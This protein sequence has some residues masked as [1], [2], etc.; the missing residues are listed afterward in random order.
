M[1]PFVISTFVGLALA[2]GATV[3]CDATAC[4]ARL[5]QAGLNEKLLA[6]EATTS[7]LRADVVAIA[8]PEWQRE[9]SKVS[10]QMRRFDPLADAPAEV[11]ASVRLTVPFT[12]QAPDAKWYPPYAEA[13]E[14]ASLLMVEYFL[15]GEAFPKGVADR[16]IVALTSWHTEHGYG[17]DV[18]TQQTATF[19]REYFHRNA[20]VYTGDDVTLEHIKRLLTAG[21]PVIIPAAGA[22]LGNIHFQ[23]PPPPYHMLVITGYDATHFFAHDPGTRFGADYAYGQQALLDA[24]HDW[25]GDKRTVSDGQRAMLIVGPS[26][27]RG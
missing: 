5:Y 2:L 22:E 26:A 27:T 8:E 9:S 16:E 17:E 6:N 7:P 19:A 10:P 21:H 11:P 20:K 4:V 14:E 12:P 25:T 1:Y 3:Y 15:R 13:C 18:T 23:V 24:I